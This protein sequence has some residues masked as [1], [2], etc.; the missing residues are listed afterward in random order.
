MADTPR[1][2]D[3]S[4]TRR[5]FEDRFR[6]ARWLIR[7]WFLIWLASFFLGLAWVFG[8]VEW[9]GLWSTIVG[10]I[11]VFVSFPI[12]FYYGQ[13]IERRFGLAC[14]YCHSGL[15][16]LRGLRHAHDPSNPFTNGGFCSTCK[17]R[18]LRDE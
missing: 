9:G 10:V 13:R 2:N 1:T 17:N 3:L 4:I 18:I 14:P 5:E 7:G 8:P 15:L 12:A 16:I 6:R 11:L